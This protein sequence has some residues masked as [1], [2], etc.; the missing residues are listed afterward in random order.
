M[1]AMA[2]KDAVSRKYIAAALLRN[3]K[4]AGGGGGQTGHGRQ[5][6]KDRRIS[7]ALDSY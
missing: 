4:A 5:G 3:G 2:T 1:V 6:L 7:Q